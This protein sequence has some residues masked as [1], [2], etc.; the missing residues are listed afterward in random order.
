ME[1][2]AEVE[3]EG[4]RISVR[5]ARGSWRGIMVVLSLVGKGC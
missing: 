3:F 1:E 5:C 2:V 4:G